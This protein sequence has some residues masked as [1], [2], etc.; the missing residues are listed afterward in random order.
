MQ[1]AQQRA[2]QR[3]HVLFSP[4]HGHDV[5][6]H[7]CTSPLLSLSSTMIRVWLLGSEIALPAWRL[8]AQN[9]LQESLKAAKKTVK[10]K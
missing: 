8:A 1:R 10:K 9:K 4:P 5:S 3:A 7:L 6:F 2:Q